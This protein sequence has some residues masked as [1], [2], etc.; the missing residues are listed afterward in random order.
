[1]KPLQWCR[2]LETKTCWCTGQIYISKLTPSCLP[3]PWSLQKIRTC[4]CRS[5]PMLGIFLWT[6]TCSLDQLA[7]NAPVWRLVTA[8]LQIMLFCHQH[9]LCSL[10]FVCFWIFSISVLYMEMN[11]DKEGGGGVAYLELSYQN[12]N[13]ILFVVWGSP[14]SPQILLS[15]IYNWD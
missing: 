7:T 6:Q 3:L 1:M 12:Y 2:L 9:G 13:Q 10:Y 8:L 4:S 15:Y 11:R 14:R 5:W